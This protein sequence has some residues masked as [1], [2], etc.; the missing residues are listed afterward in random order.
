MRSQVQVRG[1]GYVAID[2]RIALTDSS[3][4][5]TGAV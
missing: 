3:G 1:T 5:G 2:R 4:E